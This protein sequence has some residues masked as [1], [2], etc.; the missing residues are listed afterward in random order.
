[1][2]TDAWR[3]PPAGQ[4]GRT[5]RRGVGCEDGEE[6]AAEGGVTWS[7]TWKERQGV[8]RGL[9]GAD[10]HPHVQHAAAELK[11]GMGGCEKRLG[12][13]PGSGAAA[14]HR[15]RVLGAIP[16]HPALGSGRAAPAPRPPAPGRRT[17][18]SLQEARRRRARGAGATGAQPASSRTGPAGRT[19]RPPPARRYRPTPAPPPRPRTSS[20]LPRPKH[21]RTPAPPSFGRWV[22]SWPGLPPGPR[23]LAACPGHGRRS[24]PR[25]QAALHAPQSSGPSRLSVKNRVGSAIS[26]RSISS[27]I[28]PPPPN[29][30]PGPRPASLLSN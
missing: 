24:P 26:L 14:T 11:G 13:S 16:G 4:G 19:R 25:R 27:A 22:P 2:S 20:A 17:A 8:P 12:P 18:C 9:G 21:R 3:G 28:F 1:M 23:F 30:E 6:E 10:I 15:G 5:R 29:H 7:P